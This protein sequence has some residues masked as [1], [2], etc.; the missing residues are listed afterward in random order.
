MPAFSLTTCAPGT[1]YDCAHGCCVPCSGS[2]PHW[3]S[4][5]APPPSITPCDSF[6]LPN[7][8]NGL[9]LSGYC[10]VQLAA[11]Y[12]ANGG[13]A[14]LLLNMA[15]FLSVRL[16]SISLAVTWAPQC[17]F[18]LTGSSS[19]AQALHELTVLLAA[20]ELPRDASALAVLDAA[21][22]T[23]A[24]GDQLR[25]QLFAQLNANLAA[26]ST[27]I[28]FDAL[29]LLPSYPATQFSHSATPSKTPSS[30][31][32]P[33]NT[34]SSTPPMLG[35]DAVAPAADGSGVGASAPALSAGAF[36]GI[37]VAAFVVAAALA[38]VAVR[39][40]RGA[41]LPAPVSSTAAATVP[42][43]APPSIVVAGGSGG[44][45]ALR[46][47][48]VNSPSAAGGSSGARVMS[49]RVGGVQETK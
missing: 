14:G 3:C 35:G 30:T 42:A 29:G 16:G 38:A 4:S 40:R 36:A 18:Q 11:G 7:N 8:N 47:R 44:A 48:A 25:G 31:G 32:T 27:G 37:G 41:P 34:P 12:S 22:V 2:P 1:T 49:A 39:A 43:G 24:Q 13:T 46:R 17:T 6:A 10:T 23:G 15:N 5:L 9:V 21:Q 28:Q 19:D 33:S 20:A 26:F 45:S